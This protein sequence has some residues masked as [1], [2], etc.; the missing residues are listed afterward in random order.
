MDLETATHDR[1]RLTVAHRALRRV[2]RLGCAAE[3]INAHDARDRCQVLALRLMVV[4][5]A[6]RAVGPESF[7]PLYQATR[8]F[9]ETLSAIDLAAPFPAAGVEQPRR[10]FIGIHI[11]LMTV[12]GKGPGHP[13]H[14]AVGRL[15]RLRRLIADDHELP[16][17]AGCNG[18]LSP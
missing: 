1:T 4:V 14:S 15:T 3:I 18:L 9:A 16:D 13:A 5:R 12:L 8:A 10:G 6:P 17:D 11:L 7:E 2:R